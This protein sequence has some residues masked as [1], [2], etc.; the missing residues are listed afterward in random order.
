MNIIFYLIFG[1]FCGELIHFTVWEGIKRKFKLDNKKIKTIFIFVG[2]AL[3]I[4]LI[5][6]GFYRVQSYEN[7]VVTSV[8]G[9]KT[10][11]ED[12]G[13]KYSLLSSRENID[14]RKQKITYPYILDSIE[15]VT[16]D[17][18]VIKISGILEYEIE[19]IKK[20]AIENKDTEE[21]LYDYLNSRITGKIK[22]LD[23]SYI[24]ENRK[25]I[26]EGITE[27]LRQTDYGANIIRFYFITIENNYEVITA[28]AR[29][30]S[31]RI[32]SEAEKMVNEMLKSS[33]DKYTPEQ[34]DYLK[35]KMLSESGDIKWVITDK[36]SG[37]IVNS[38]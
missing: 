10:V 33:L 26:E 5:G 13:I 3:I 28:K 6:S 37:V 30:E 8:L 23:Y 1:W 20:W 19:D 7:V 18:K 9:E 16:K 36:D 35:I 25:Y 11:K 29:A 2:I 4:S 22:S 38:E 15:I 27:E 21:K 32:N 31:S 12:V 14:L 24:L 34:L 17:N